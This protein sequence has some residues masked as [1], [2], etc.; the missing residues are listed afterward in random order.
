MENLIHSGDHWILLISLISI[1]LLM[2]LKTRLFGI[3]G[4]VLTTIYIDRNYNSIRA[5]FH[6]ALMFVC[7]YILRIALQR[8]ALSTVSNKK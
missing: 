4:A 8:Y 6:V 3:I 1:A 2:R 7:V 5:V